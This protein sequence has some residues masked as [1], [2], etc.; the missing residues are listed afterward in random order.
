MRYLL[1]TNVLSRLARRIDQQIVEK[2][3][4]HE[5]E[6]VVSAVAWYELEYGVARSPQPGR[7]RA[8]LSYLRE[9]FP[10]SAPFDEFAAA[11]AASVRMFLEGM[12][13]NAQPIG[14]YD[15]LLAGHAIAL[16]AI[17]VTHNPGEFGRV[18]GLK[19]EDWQQS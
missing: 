3:T 19:V 11:R 9:I 13:P 5:T 2:V 7:A 17:F 4:R 16:G 14:P 12:R 6:C 15:V 1:D 10:E 18:S 8:R